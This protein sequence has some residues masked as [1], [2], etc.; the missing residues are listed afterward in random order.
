M[1]L[2][3]Q[4]LVIKIYKPHIGRNLEV[5]I[6]EMLVSCENSPIATNHITDL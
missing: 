4:H 3:Y 5:Y 2:F 1:G 6:D